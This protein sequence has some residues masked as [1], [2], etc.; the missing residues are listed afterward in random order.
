MPPDRDGGE[1]LQRLKIIG[2]KNSDNIMPRQKHSAKGSTGSIRGN[3]LITIDLDSEIKIRINR[4]LEK[5]Y[6]LMCDQEPI[7]TSSIADITHSDE[8]LDNKDL[9]SQLINSQLR[10]IPEGY[11]ILREATRSGYFNIV[12][13][14]VDAGADIKLRDKVTSV[15]EHVIQIVTQIFILYRK[16]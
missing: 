4:Q 7:N 12:T 8:W 3:S 14:L 9:T 11:H 16:G 1:T 6:D 10:L 15:L 2:K 13:S 5:I